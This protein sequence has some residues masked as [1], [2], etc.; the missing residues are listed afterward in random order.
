MICFYSLPDC[1]LRYFLLE[2]LD[3]QMIC[4]FTA[5]N[6]NTHESF[7]FKE[8]WFNNKNHTF[9]S[10]YQNYMSDGRVISYAVWLSK[11]DKFLQC[12]HLK[13]YKLCSTLLQRRRLSKR[14]N[15]SLAIFLKRIPHICQVNINLSWRFATDVL[16]L[17]PNLTHLTLTNDDG[18]ITTSNLNQFNRVFR[19]LTY[20]H[21]WMMKIPVPLD[22]DKYGYCLRPFRLVL[23]I[24]GACCYSKLKTLVLDLY[25]PSSQQQLCAKQVKVKLDTCQ[26]RDTF[27]YANPN[28]SVTLRSYLKQFCGVVHACDDL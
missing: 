2:W 10:M 5:A 25:E 19:K 8:M 4:K 11:Q 24:I 6:C 17:Q 13:S 20:L 3:E 22:E 23:R 21:I 26:D 12:L 27:D 16:D 15:P 14:L 9:T 1:F 28:G 18:M 7:H